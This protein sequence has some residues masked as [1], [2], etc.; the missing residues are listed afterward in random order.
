V[1]FA[2]LTCSLAASRQ[3][4]PLGDSGAELWPVYASLA[5]GKDCQLRV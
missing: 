5:T 3:L 1:L 4:A 2:G